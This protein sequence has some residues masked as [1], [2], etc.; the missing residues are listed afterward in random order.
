MGKAILVTGG[1]RSGKSSYAEKLAKELHGNVLYIA[2]S[3]P[4]DE[5]MKTRIK[6]HRES[7]PDGWDTY[8]GFRGL[9]KVVAEK[10]RKYDTIL[11]DCITVMIANLLLDYIGMDNGDAAYEDF[12]EAESEIKKE[13]DDLL[14][15]ISQ[16]KAIV[17]IVTNEL[18]SGIVPENLMS[19]VF[20][21]VAGRMNQYIAEQCDEVFITVC[22]LPL[23][24]K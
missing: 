18:G 17:I 11:I 12:L 7:R 21:D 24:L 2:T 16:T 4:F 23:R 19:R 20:R 1:A 13:I 9:G 22:G 15:G 10:G 3:I 6:K 8:E 14:A 5:E